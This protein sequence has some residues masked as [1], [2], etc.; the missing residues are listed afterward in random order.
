MGESG[1]AQMKRRFRPRVGKGDGRGEG[2]RDG[3]KKRKK[4]VRRVPVCVAPIG[5]RSFFRGGGRRCSVS[6]PDTPWGSGC[7]VYLDDRYKLE[8]RCYALNL[9]GVMK[10]KLPLLVV[11]LG[12]AVAGA[13]C[14]FPSSGTVYDRRQVGH[15]MSVE[16]GDIVSIRNV[17]VEGRNTVIGTGGGAIVG[18]AAASGG[19]GVGGAIAQAAGVVGGAIAGEAVEEVATRGTAQEL[20]IKTSSGRTIAVVQVVGN[21]GPF[22]VGEHVQLLDGAGGTT[23]R[24]LN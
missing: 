24:R 13:G 5:A 20:M 11:S 7:S 23:V 4:W 18:G 15:S 9:S 14:K 2:R 16:T 19:S 1:V 3:H 17:K 21:E 12:L 22:A 8:K 6:L 10:M